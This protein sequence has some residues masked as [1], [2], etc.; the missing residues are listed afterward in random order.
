MIDVYDTIYDTSDADEFATLADRAVD[1]LDSTSIG[2]DDAEPAF[3]DR[4]ACLDLA[5]I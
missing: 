1:D 4:T 2:D 3:L 5:S